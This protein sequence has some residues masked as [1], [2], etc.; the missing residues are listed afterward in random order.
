M[1]S[2]TLVLIGITVL[3]F[4]LLALKNIFN[5]KKAC[6]ICL[7]VTLS[8]AILLALYFL[9]I[10]ND[11]IIIAILMGHTSL[12]LFYI[13]EK[14]VKKKFLLFR[15]PYLLTSIF[16][17][18][19]ILEDFNINNMFFILALW[20]LFFIIY[21]LKFNKFATKLIECCKKW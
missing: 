17:I 20:V 8:W 9:N 2:L 7:S 10:F 1:G 3:F 16:I 14:K 4:L 21:V 6:V 5:L 15:L 19:S 12:G 18:Y 13:L 11:K